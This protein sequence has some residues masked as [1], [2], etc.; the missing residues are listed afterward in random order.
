MYYWMWRVPVPNRWLPFLD[1]RIVPFVPQHW[2][3]V[4]VWFTNMYYFSSINA[5]IQRFPNLTDYRVIHR[6]S[7]MCPSCR[8]YADCHSACHEAVFNSFN[9]NMEHYSDRVR[10]D[11]VMYDIEAALHEVRFTEVRNAGCPHAYMVFQG[12]VEFPSFPT[13]HSKTLEGVQMDDLGDEEPLVSSLE[14]QL[15][16]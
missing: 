2:R 3:R 7:P 4:F 1:N 15:E 6:A 14:F 12:E 13:F 10:C 16:T 9:S 11:H 5:I 8:S